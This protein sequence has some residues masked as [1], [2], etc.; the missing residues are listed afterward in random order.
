MISYIDCISCHIVLPN[1]RKYLF[2]F[3]F[4]FGLINY[5]EVEIYHQKN[6]HS[7][8]LPGFPA[9]APC[10]FWG[11]AVQWWWA[12]DARALV[13]GIP[14]KSFRWNLARNL[15]EFTKNMLRYVGFSKVQIH[16][17]EVIYSKNHN[18]M[19]TVG[20]VAVLAAA[21]QLHSVE[22][23]NHIWWYLKTGVPPNHPFSCIINSDFL[24]EGYPKPP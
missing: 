18:L 22:N 3:Y 15:F 23:I 2:Q 13:P 6:V 12:T 8:S 16:W 21:T 14:R 7:Q 4:V 17:C 19:R 10:P 1:P 11:R 5:H 24:K 9:R 20:F